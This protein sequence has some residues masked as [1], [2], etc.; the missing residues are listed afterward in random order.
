MYISFFLWKKSLFYTQLSGS[1]FAMS[2]SLIARPFN[3]RS[4]ER[5]IVAVPEVIVTAPVVVFSPRRRSLGR[6]SRGKVPIVA[7]GLLYWWYC[8][9]KLPLD[10][11]LPVMCFGD[12][13]WSLYLLKSTGCGK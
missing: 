2:R 8:N 9:N 12:F 3:S 6:E 7:T 1:R 5:A 11:Y 4:V 13:F 10:I